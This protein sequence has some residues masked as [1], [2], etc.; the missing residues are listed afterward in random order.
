M[1]KQRGLTRKLNQQEKNSSLNSGDNQRPLPVSSEQTQSVQQ[2][3][4]DTSRTDKI[5][6]GIYVQKGMDKDKS[7]VQIFL[8]EKDREFPSLD[9]AGKITHCVCHSEIIIEKLCLNKRTNDYFN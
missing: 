8:S 4:I 2:R 9:D 1:S 7:R 6:S 3:P 5:I